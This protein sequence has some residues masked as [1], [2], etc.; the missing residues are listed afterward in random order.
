M[1]GKGHTRIRL[2][3]QV[4]LEVRCQAVRVCSWLSAKP[5]S[6][7]FS[8]GKAVGKQMLC[9]LSAIRSADG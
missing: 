5:P 3:L 8:F 6:G 1:T 9:S 7:C 2:D 4:T